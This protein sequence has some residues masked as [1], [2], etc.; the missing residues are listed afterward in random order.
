MCFFKQW[1]IPNCP[2]AI[3]GKHVV[4]QALEELVLPFI[5]IKGHI[6]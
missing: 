3:D 4:M 2:G 6:P 5:T 1:N